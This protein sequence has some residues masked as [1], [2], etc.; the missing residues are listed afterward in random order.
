M[1]SRMDWKQISGWPWVGAASKLWFSAC[2][3]VAF[4]WEPS[5]G[6]IAAMVDFIDGNLLSWERLSQS[7]FLCSMTIMA[8]SWIPGADSS[9]DFSLANI[10]FGIVTT[11]ADP[12]PRPS[13]AIGE[14]VLDLKALTKRRDLASIFGG[15]NLNIARLR[16]AFCSTTLNPFAALGR[17][18][19]R[20]VREKL[21]DVLSEQTS[22][23]GFLRDDAA[24]RHEVLITKEKV[25]M[26]LPMQ[27]GDY[28]DFYAG[29][30]H[31]YHVGAM[32][33]GPQNALQPNYTHLPVGY[34]GRSSS[35]VVSG[36]PIRRPHGQLLP[37]PSAET[38][39]PITESSRK[40]DIELELACFISTPNQMGDPVRIED[41]EEHIFGYVL[42]NDWS[43]RDIQAWEYVPLGPFNGKNFATSISPWVVLAD[44]LEPFRVPSLRNE[45][46]LQ[47]YLKE[48][49]QENVF[50]I[51]LEVDLRS[52]RNPSIESQNVFLRNFTRS[53]GA[54]AAAEL[55]SWLA[56]SILQRNQYNLPREFRKSHLVLPADDRPPH[57]R[58]MSTANR[59]PP[60]VRDHQRPFGQR[61]GQSPRAERRRHEGHP[62]GRGCPQ[63]PG[64]RRCRNLQSLL[65][66]TRRKGWVRQVCGEDRERHP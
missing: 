51:Q 5:T 66:K 54:F 29:Y 34:H 55:T 12:V 65:R 39:Q 33:R 37:N 40:L 24:L 18:A 35:I 25:R 61:A 44:A 47:D 13:V 20:E 7:L 43:A 21:Q 57:P 2:I 52:K 19:H 64:R 49:R 50:D 36:T 16:H 56:F 46:P 17:A 63:V 15:S 31:A 10:P 3:G 23:P 30:H 32:F 27:I 6:N 11:E 62:G 4:G 53:N 45:T 59:R 8:K 48:Q 22:A 42:L 58:R 9:T 1:V 28:T 60:R 38:K 26:C 14:F 41:A